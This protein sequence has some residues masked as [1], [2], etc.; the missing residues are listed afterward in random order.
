MTLHPLT[1]VCS[2]LPP[3][4][5]HTQL[6]FLEPSNPVRPCF[7]SSLRSSIQNPIHLLRGHLS[8]ILRLL[9]AQLKEC[10]SNGGILGLC[11]RGPALRAGWSSLCMWAGG[12]EELRHN[13]YGLSVGLGLP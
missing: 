7:F 5:A 11:W 2:L 12:Q 8:Q 9:T 6:P 1:F 13:L 4:C 10:I 3:C